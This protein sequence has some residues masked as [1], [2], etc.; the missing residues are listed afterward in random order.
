MKDIIK[1]SAILLVIVVVFS[2]AMFGLNFITGPI[3]EANNAGAA[4]APLLAVMPEGASFG[5][6]ALI[7]DTLTSL[8][9]SVTAVYKEANGLGY[10]IRTSATSQYSSAP[11]EIT[12]G[13]A[14]DGKICG[15]QI[16]SYND[17]ENYDFRAKDP[18]YL[19]SYIGQDSALADV[20]TVSGSTFSSTAFRSAVEEAMSVLI[21]ND[22]I[23]AGV[24]TPAQILTELIPTVAPGFTSAGIL[25][26][27]EL[28]ASGNIATAYKAMNGSGFAF[29][30][31]EGESSYLALVNAIG[32][33]KL[34][35]V[36]GKDVTADKAALTEEAKTASADQENF[37][38]ALKAKVSSVMK[39]ATDIAP[40]EFDSFGNVVCAV[41]F[42]VADATYYG[43]YS[44]PL[45]YGDSAMQIFTI[46]DANG[47]IVKQTV[48]E[49]L[50]GHGVEYLPVYGQFGD[51]LSSDYKNYENGFAGLNK[52]TF[53]SHVMISGAT[54]SSTAV[55]TAMNDVFDIFNTIKNGGAN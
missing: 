40:V 49:M 50:F 33:V 12:I 37:F 42:K 10:V 24:K 5:N 32:T 1:A 13:I 39:D 15:I 45:S 38:D 22:M 25:K 20:G 9:T 6:D 19:N 8:P 29:I 11:M 48:A 17:T 7:T 35:D 21:A 41:E 31:T 51:P 47:A 14:A 54:V 46:L 52:D 34:Y 4:L 16:D 43:F 18:N 2:A 27:E 28:T 3:I 36:E 23:A 30:M 55:K 44:R 26:C 53:D